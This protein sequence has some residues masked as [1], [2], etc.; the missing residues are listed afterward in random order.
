[1]NIF[2]VKSH[3]FATECHTLCFDSCSFP[4]E[5][6]VWGRP[7]GH[8]TEYRTLH[9]SACHP[10]AGAMLVFCGRSYFNTR[11]AEASTKWFPL[12]HL[13]AVHTL[14]SPVSHPLE[15]QGKPSKYFLP[16]YPLVCS[17][18]KHWW[19]LIVWEAL[20][21]QR[22]DRFV[23]ASRTSQSSQA[24]GGHVTNHSTAIKADATALLHSKNMLQFSLNYLYTTVLTQKLS[25]LTKR[26][27]YKYF[28][29]IYTSKEGGHYI[30]WYLPLIITIPSEVS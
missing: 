21:S 6:R 25:W 29:F 16:K 20:G 27:K 8:R 30:L 19:R 28:P 1:M 10:C 4:A 14:R 22:G 5:Q 11:A 15:K 12:E 2:I 23:P 3:N 26:Q 18:N 9:K 17:F 7:A 24:G 13:F